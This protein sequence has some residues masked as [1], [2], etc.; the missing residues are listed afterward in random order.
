LAH[1]SSSPA[2][3]YD[4]AADCL[5]DRG[6]RAMP[7]PEPACLH[8]D[9]LARLELGVVEQHVLAPSPN[10]IG[11]AGGLVGALTPSGTAITSQLGPGR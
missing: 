8:E 5:C 1:F 7:M 9:G 3:A 10:A 4:G 2:V 6:W 11:G